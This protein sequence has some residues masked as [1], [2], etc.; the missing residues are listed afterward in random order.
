[1]DE[2]VEMQLFETKTMWFVNVQSVTVSSETAEGGIVVQRNQDYEQVYTAPH[3]LRGAV[4]ELVTRN[5][6]F[7]LFEARLCHGFTPLQYVPCPH[8]HLGP[9]Q[10]NCQVD[11]SVEL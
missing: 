1:V 3:L 11:H 9:A 8:R 2:V 6:H 5:L 10:V 7:R 4:V